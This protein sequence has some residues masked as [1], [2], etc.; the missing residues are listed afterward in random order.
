MGYLALGLLLIGAIGLVIARR[1]RYTNVQTGRIVQLLLVAVL[2]VGLVLTVFTTFYIVNPGEVA[3]E[4]L[5]G[6]IQGYRENGF[7]AKLP[8]ADVHVFD[9]KTQKSHQDCEAA[10]SD[11]QIVKVVAVIN[12]RLDSTKIAICTSRSAATTRARSCCR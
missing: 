8:I 12:Y 1:V 2:A 10:S 7:H 9:I 11:L 5:F 4:V 3:V 6:N